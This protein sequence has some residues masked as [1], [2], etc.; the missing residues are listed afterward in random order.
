MLGTILEFARRRGVIKENPARGVERLP[1]GRQTRFLSLA[2]I[3]ALGAA[4]RRAEAAGENPVA[5]AAV[6]FLL[7]SGCRRMEALALPLAVGGRRRGLHPLPRRQGHQGAR[8]SA[9][10]WSCA[11]S[12]RRRCGRSPPSRGRRGALGPSPPRAARGT[13]SGCRACWSGC[14]PGRGSRT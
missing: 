5:L 2:E 3:G 14:A 1:E 12:A 4:M 9:A 6:R 10:G 13:W 8:G 7:L 11:R